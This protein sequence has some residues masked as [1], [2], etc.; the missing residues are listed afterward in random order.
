VVT[1]LAVQTDSGSL[2]EEQ[3]EPQVLEQVE[4]IGALQHRVADTAAD[5]FVYSGER[6]SCKVA[7][8][9]ARCVSAGVE[10]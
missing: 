5:D 6:P 3:G 1:L 7:V 10:A 2:Q 8:A 4:H 9:Q